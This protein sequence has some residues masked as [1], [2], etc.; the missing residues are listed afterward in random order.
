MLQIL[1]LTYSIVLSDWM[2]N[3]FQSIVV[4]RRGDL[5][6]GATSLRLS[7]TRNIHVAASPGS[8]NEDSNRDEYKLE[9]QY[10]TDNDDDEI[11]T[12]EL[13]P[14]P[15]SKNSG[16]RFVALLWNRE[17]GASSDISIDDPWELHEKHISVTEDHVMFC[18]KANLYNET[19]NTDS[20]VDVVWS[21][22]MYVRV[23]TSATHSVP[24]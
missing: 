17:L 24:Y 10:K 18:R 5:P 12:V 11:P 7:G 22:P 13:Q 16:N 9:Q 21:L 1:T 2:A 4:A 19:F 8:S 20:M 15:M 23:H 6:L 14:I 3:G